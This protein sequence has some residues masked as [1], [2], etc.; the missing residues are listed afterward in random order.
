M[1]FIVN[2]ECDLYTLLEWAY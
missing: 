2:L 1:Q